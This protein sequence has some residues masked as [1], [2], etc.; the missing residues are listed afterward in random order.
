MRD[1][2]QEDAEKAWV[3]RFAERGRAGT[4]LAVLEPGAIRPG[5]EI[6]VQHSGSGLLIT[7]LLRAWMGD[8]DQMRVA[9]APDDLDAESQGYF[10]RKLAR[11]SQRSA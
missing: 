1:L 11:R 6:T 9:L 8:L 5:D 7:S 4:Y 2:R 10:T 3:R